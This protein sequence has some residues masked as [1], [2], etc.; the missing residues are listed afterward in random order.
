MTNEIL[1]CQTTFDRLCAET[2]MSFNISIDRN[3]ATCGGRPIHVV[4]ETHPHVCADNMIH[5]GC[6]VCG[7][8]P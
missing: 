5:V 1:M 7:K 8:K 6:A 2:E 4:A 3:N